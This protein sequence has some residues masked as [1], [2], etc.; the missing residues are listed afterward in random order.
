MLYISNANRDGCRKARFNHRFC[1]LTLLNHRLCASIQ[2]HLW[3][4]FDIFEISLSLS[5]V[6]DLSKVLWPSFSLI[7]FLFALSLFI[8]LSGL[9]VSEVATIC[10]LLTNNNV[11]PWSQWSSEILCSAVFSN[12]L[13]PCRTFRSDF[14]QYKANLIHVFTRN[15]FWSSIE[16]FLKPFTTTYSNDNG[17]SV[18]TAPI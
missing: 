3:R 12:K 1:D 8:L 9:R 13:Q 6:L 5:S 10:Y 15:S 14:K 11:L 16:T 18:L 17:E 7:W 4:S 2:L